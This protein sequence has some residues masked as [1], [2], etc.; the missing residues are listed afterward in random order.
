MSTS[1]DNRFDP[2][3]DPASIF[4]A[5]V[6]GSD[7]VCKQC[8][9]LLHRYEEVPLEAGLDHGDILAHVEYDIPEDAE[10]DLIERRYYERVPI[11]DRLGTLYHEKGLS[12]FCRNCGT[13]TPHV[14]DE[15]FSAED[16][17]EHAANLSD[18]Y[19]T[20]RILDNLRLE[21]TVVHQSV[22]APPS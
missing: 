2:L 5:V 11:R 22:H 12:T 3:S 18:T 9:T 19:H 10:L 13:T 1:V 15:W 20:L 17:R 4:D 16:V 7:R 14:R 6:I 21:Q 8:M